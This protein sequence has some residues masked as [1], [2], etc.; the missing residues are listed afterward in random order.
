MREMLERVVERWGAAITW[1]HDGKEEALRGFFQPVTAR[2]W[3]KLKR[4]VT[5]LGDTPVGMYVYIGAVSR[6]VEAGDILTVGE[7]QYEIRRTEIIYDG[8]G[9]V[10]RWALCARK[11]GV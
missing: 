1:H 10:Y 2:S 6:P 3:Q 8:K 11:G 5:P 4:Q 7:R 9:P